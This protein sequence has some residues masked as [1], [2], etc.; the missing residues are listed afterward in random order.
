MVTLEKVRRDAPW[1]WIKGAVADMRAAPLVSIG[2]GAVFTGIGIAITLGLWSLGLV[3]YAPVLVGG[4]ALVAPIFA[5]GI[6][7]VSQKRDAGETPQLLDFWRISGSRLSQIGLLSVLLFVFFLAWARLAQ[8]LFVMIVAGD[9]DFRLESMAGFMFTDPAGVTLLA[10]GAAIGAV[11][12]FAAFTVAALSFPMIIDQDV[13]AI[14]A[15]VASVKAVVKQPLVMVTWAWLIAFFIAAGAAFFLV[16]LAITFPLIAHA[17]WRAYKD[18]AP[19]P[20]PSAA[21]MEARRAQS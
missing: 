6:Y 10:V 18:F 15:L 19:K 16:G 7:R 13:D 20:K 21:A 11:L 14:T 12:A 4:F 1:S 3:G 17:S 5:V 8:F 2:Y 9:A